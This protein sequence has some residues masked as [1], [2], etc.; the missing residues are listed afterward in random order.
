[1]TELLYGRQA[2]VEALRAGRRKIVTLS[3]AENAQRKGV[4]AESI[5]LAERRNIPVHYVPHGQLIHALRAERAEAQ[6]IVAEVREY[7]YVD[8]DALMAASDERSG[9]VLVMDRVQDPQN[10]GTLLRTA[11]AV[12]VDGVIIPEHRAAS[13]TPAVVNASSGATEHLRI[14]RVTNMTRALE[15]LKQAGLWVAGLESAPGALDYTQADLSG[16]LAL[17]VG[18]EGQ[19]ISRLVR[20]TCDF[21]VRLPMR[22][23]IGSLNVAVAGSIALYEIARQRRP[24]TLA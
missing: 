2:V 18:S 17:V 3:V 12:G 11:E 15:G 8:V 23:R 22:G 13:I 21:L 14:A 7:P 5:A 6:G 4:L 20:E 16:P 9:L 24:A 10:V 1:M 19:G